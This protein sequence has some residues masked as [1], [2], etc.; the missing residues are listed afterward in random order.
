MEPPHETVSTVDSGQLQLVENPKLRNRL[1]RFFTRMQLVEQ[2]VDKN[3]FVLVDEICSVFLVC[4]GITVQIF[5]KDAIT[6]VSRAGNSL[7][8]ISAQTLFILRIAY[9]HKRPTRT[10]GTIFS[11]SRFSGLASRLSARRMRKKRWS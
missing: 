8:G 3:N 7:T 9:C 11:A 4:A 1:I 10:R 2:I 6:A 5:E